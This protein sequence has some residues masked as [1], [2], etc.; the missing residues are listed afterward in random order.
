M[1]RG[2]LLLF[3]AIGTVSAETSPNATVPEI[4]LPPAAAISSPE[5]DHPKRLRELIDTLDQASMQEAFRLLTQDYIQHEV[6]DDLE[7]NRS[8]LQGMLNRLDFGAMLLTEKSRSERNSPFVF[9]Q[10]KLTPQIGYVRFG[11]FVDSE[12]EAFDAAIAGFKEE[13]GL[14]H[15]ILDLRSP[16][17]QAEFAIAAKILSRLRPP[18]EL[19]FKIRRPGNE[20]PSLFVSTAV[21]GGWTGDLILLVDGETGNVGEI[22]A[23]VLKRETGCLV[24][25]EQTPGLA[26][27]YRDVPVGEDRILRFAVA[28]V[29]LEDDTSIFQKGITP[30]LINGTVPKTKYDIYR[31]VD[32][33]TPLSSFLFQQQRPRMNEAALVAGTDPEIDYYLLLSQQ[34]ATPWDRAPIQDRSLQQALDLLET[35]LFLKSDPKKKR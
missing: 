25:G 35:T 10:A 8:A 3:L 23:A 14:T 34:K 12:L 4:P 11:R 19:L 5:T 7:V 21:S 1:I 6:L 29:V 33:G 31:A 17:A 22:I 16:Q 15:L 26:V 2:L 28:E 30:D 24:I 27:E 18:N 20:R 9:Q 13:K 32:K